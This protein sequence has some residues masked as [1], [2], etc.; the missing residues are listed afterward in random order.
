MFLVRMLVVCSILGTTAVSAQP[1]PAPPPPAPPIPAG[2]VAPPDAPPTPP[3]PT[4]TPTTPPT[5]PTPTPSTPPDAPPPTSPPPAVI[6]P[7]VVAAPLVAAAPAGLS[8][9]GIELH[10]FV[11]QGGFATTANDYLGHRASLEFFEAALNASTEPVDRLR[12]GM[13]LFARDI[14]NLGGYD[15]TLD[16]AFIDYRWRD[17]LG[18]RAGHIKM[19]FGL[20]NEYA[21]IDAARL[22]ILLPQ[23]VYPIES[24][25]VLLAHTGFSLYGTIPLAAAGTLDYQLLGGT[26][27]IPATKGLDSTSSKYLVGGQAFWHPIEGLR[28]GFSLLRASIDYLFTLP[29]QEIS[30]LVMAGLEPATFDG[31]GMLHEDP[32]TLWVASAEYV[33]GDWLFAA[34][35]S[36]WHIHSTSTLPTEVLPTTNTNNERFYALAAYRLTEQLDAGVY[37]SVY[38]ED[39]H[40][41]SGTKPGAFAEPYEAYQRDAALSLRYDV[42]DHWLW[43]LEGHFIDGDADLSLTDNP[44]PKQYW[45]MFLVKTTVTF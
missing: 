6:A 18:L 38:N 23:S 12:I 2:P 1:V 27:T 19:P 5:P 8:V 43:K 22:S 11:S 15:A 3:T 35:Y 29:Q 39:V 14:G 13:Q 31:S 34:E 33:H 37:Y 20:Y 21:D 45:G 25:D 30:T 7:A 40:D 10:G 36:R 41:R 16:W 42:N 44:S 26:V 28:A 24:Q 9:G 4:P 32:A 17:W